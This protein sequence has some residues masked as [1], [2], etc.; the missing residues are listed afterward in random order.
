VSRCEN[1]GEREAVV[2]LTQIVDNTITTLNLCEPCAAEKGVETGLHAA[3]FP[4]GDFLAS[5]G[6]GPGAAG[7]AAEADAACPSCGATLRDF[8]Q[9]GRLGCADCYR[10]FEPQLRDLLR[11]VHGN[12]Q[13]AGE[14][15]RGAAASPPPAADDSSRASGD[16]LPDLRER[17]RRAV[18]A[19]DFELAARLRDAIRGLE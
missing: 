12:A 17:L 5:L 8:R 19:E 15:Y 16:T 6:E 2:H 10:A 1:C 13:H 9:T 7:V 4:L 18:E 11:R 3:K 14:R